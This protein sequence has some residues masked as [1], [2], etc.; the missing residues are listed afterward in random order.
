[1]TC[2]SLVWDLCLRLCCTV[3][4]SGLNLHTWF[5]FYLKWGSFCPCF[6][7]ILNTNEPVRTGHRKLWQNVPCFL[8]D[9]RIV[10]CHRNRS[11]ECKVRPQSTEFFLFLRGKFPGW[12]DRSE[13]VPPAQARTCVRACV[14]HVVGTLHNLPKE[15]RLWE[16]DRTDDWKACSG[17]F[18]PHP[19]DCPAQ[20]TP[21]SQRKWH[22]HNISLVFLCF[23]RADFDRQGGKLEGVWFAVLHKCSLIFNRIPMETNRQDLRSLFWMFSLFVDKV[24]TWGLGVH[25]EFL[26]ITF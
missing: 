26:R 18:V 2:P 20:Q 5:Y 9:G 12:A 8:R 4:P 25:Y 15:W 1:M 21:A 10:F 22:H 17:V 7:C 6:S 3:V 11:L 24:L 19:A 13:T 16:K 23:F 14:S